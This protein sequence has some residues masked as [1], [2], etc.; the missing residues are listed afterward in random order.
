MSLIGTPTLVFTALVAA[1]CP[2]LCVVLWNRVRGPRAVR[3]AA[4]L[5]LLVAAQLAALAFAG[6]AVNDYGGF[7]DTWT[8]L[9][10]SVGVGPVDH[11]SH[12]PRA[13]T[14]PSP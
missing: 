1:A 11:V 6:L 8:E 14:A 13:Y 4:R 10:Q 12:V 2:V 5:G 7:Y 3:G 9:G